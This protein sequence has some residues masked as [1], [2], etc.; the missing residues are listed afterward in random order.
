MT[1]VA[2]LGG[3]LAGSTAGAALGRWPDGDTLLRPARSRCPA[4]ATLLKPRELVPLISWLA[5][6]GRCATCKEPIDRRLVLL[7]GASAVL[8]VLIIHRFGPTLIGVLLAFGGVAVLLATMTDLERRRIP[9]RLTVPLALV[10][11]CWGL[12]TSAD[13]PGLWTVLAWALGVPAALQVANLFA[14]VLNRPQPVGRGDIKLLVGVLA[15]ATAVEGGAASVLATSVV[16]AG[17]FATFGLLSGHLKRGDRVPFA[18]AIAT[19]YLVAVLVPV[20]PQAVTNWF[21]GGA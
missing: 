8:T 1:G 19:G 14:V 20:V 18:P 13:S 10:A 3:A 12:G 2:F 11:L 21:G 5:L 9:D 17:M 4:C 16:V 6:R 7:E 15:L